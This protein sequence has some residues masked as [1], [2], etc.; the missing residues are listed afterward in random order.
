MKSSEYSLQQYLDYDLVMDWQP[1]E[2][3]SFP[4]PNV[5]PAIQANSGSAF[6]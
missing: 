4:I 1:G 3:S 6:M 2:I 5:T